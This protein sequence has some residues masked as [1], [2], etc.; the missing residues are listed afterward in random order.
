M[1]YTSHTALP[2]PHCVDGLSLH[3]GYV[4]APSLHCVNGVPAVEALHISDGHIVTL[5]ADG[6][7]KK[8]GRGG[9]GGEGRVA[10]GGEEREEW[11]RGGEGRGERG[12]LKATELTLSDKNC[13]CRNDGVE[14][15]DE[16]R[17][18]KHLYT[19]HCCIRQVEEQ[20]CRCII[21]SL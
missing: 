8:S 3:S 21:S 1:C 9:R 5:H 4:V 20:N 7:L 11:G 2:L 12:T 6:P 15:R 19:T 10:E 14:G 16:G 17:K 18:K 13:A